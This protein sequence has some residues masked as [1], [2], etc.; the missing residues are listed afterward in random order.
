[1]LADTRISWKK[2]QFPPK[3]ILRKLYTLGD[4]NKSIVLGFSAGDLRAAKTVMAFLMSRKFQNYKRPL[5]IKQF[6]DDLRRWIEEVATAELSPEQ[7]QELKFMVCGVEPSRHPP[8]LKNGKVIG[9]APFVESHIYIYTIGGTGKVQV[10]AQPV[11][12]GVIGSG[13]E[14]RDE[15]RKKVNETIKFGFRQPN[16]HWARAFLINEIVASM[17]QENKLVSATVG[18]PF[19]IIRITPNGLETQYTWPPDVESKNVEVRIEDS[20]TIVHNPALGE[21]YVLHPIWEFSF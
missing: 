7:R 16:L 17:A 18:G 2:K 21:K 5:V 1:M 4:A 10:N 19:Q 12:F 20:R 15:I 11:S 14:L 9:H 8:I 13:N 6:K 3:D